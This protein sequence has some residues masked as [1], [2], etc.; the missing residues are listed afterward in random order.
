MIRISATATAPATASDFSVSG[1]PIVIGAGQTI[2][3]SASDVTITGVDDST[4]G[5]QKTVTVSGAAL[6]GRI[7]QPGAKTLTITDD[8]TPSTGVTLTVLPN[9]VAEDAAAAD[10]TVTVVA[11]LNGASRDTA[12]TITVSV[13]GVTATAGTHYVAVDDFAVTIPANSVSGRNTFTLEPVDDEVDAPDRTVRVTGTTTASGLTVTIVDDDPS[14]VVTLELSPG[15]ISEDGGVSTVTATLD[16][17]SSGRT[18]VDVTAA[19]VAPAVAGDYRLSGNKRLTI[20]AGQTASTGTVT[21]TGVDNEVAAANKEVEVSGT[22]TTTGTAV[23]QPDVLMLTITDN[24]QASTTVT[25]SVSPDAISEGATGSARTVQVTAALD[26]AARSTDTTV[27]MT[28]ASGTAIA[29]TDFAAVSDFTVTI[30]AGRRSGNATFA[31]TPLDD[32][33]DEPDET[34]LVTGSLSTPGLALEPEGGLTVTIEDNEPE[35]LV[36]LVLTPDSIREDGGATTVTATLDSPSTAVTTI[37]VAASPVAPAVEGDFRLIGSQLTISIGETASTGSVTIEAVDNEVEAPNKRVTVSATT[38]NVLGVRDPA[39]RTLTI[40]DNEF[41]STAVTLSVLPSEIGEGSPQT[42]EVSA[43]L[44]GAAR[45]VDTDIAITVGP[46]T[47]VASDFTPVNGFTLIIPAEQKSGMA[48]FTLV[49][50]NDET[51]EPDET[52]RVSGRLSGLRMEPSGGVTVTLVDDDD[53]PE[54]TLVLTPDS[55]I[56]NGGVST[57]T[58]SLDQR[59]SAMP[60]D[61][62]MILRWTPPSNDGGSEVTGYEYR[63]DGGAWS[64]VGGGATAAEFTVQNLTNGRT[65]VFGMRAVNGVGEGAEATVRAFPARPPGA[66][67]DLAVTSGDG[68][69]DVT[70]TAPTDDGG[71]PVTH[72]EVDIDRTGGWIRAS[73]SSSHRV[74]QL[75]N[76]TAYTFRVRA[77]NAAGGGEPSAAVSATPATVPGA[78]MAL[79]AMPRDGRVD[80]SWAAPSSDGGLAIS[81]YEVEVDGSGTWTSTGNT[82]T[83]YTVGGLTNGTTYRFRV[84]AVSDSGPGAASS[85]IATA[86][87]ATARAPDVPRAL[88][89]TPAD[90]AVTLSWIAPF[91]DGGAALLRYEVERDG[92]GT[93]TSTGNTSATYTAGGLTNGTSYRFRVRAVNSEGA[94]PATSAASAVPTTT[95][96]SRAAPVLLPAMRALNVTRASEASGS[97]T[98]TPAAMPGVPGNP[99]ATPGDG[100]VTLAWSAPAGS[101]P[102]T[103]YEVQ[104]DAGAWTATGGTA[105][106]YTVAG[107]VNGT[108]YTFRVRALNV[109]RASEASGSVTTTPTI[110]AGIVFTPSSVS[111]SEAESATYTVL[112]SSPPVGPLTVAPSV[113]DNVDV[114]VSPERLIFQAADWQTAQTVT[115]TAAA[116]T[117]EDSETATIRHTVTG[118]G[119]GAVEAGTV[120]VVVRD[121]S[122]EALTAVVLTVDPASVPEDAG[123]TPLTVTAQLADGSEKRDVEVTLSLGAGTAQEGINFVAVEPVTLTI[124]AG[125]A[126]ATA[127]VTLTPVDDT[128]DRPDGEDATVRIEASTDANTVVRP[129]SL[130]VT[131]ADDEESGLVVALDLQPG[132]AVVSVADAAVHEAAGAVLEFAV[133]LGPAQA[134]EIRVG[135]ATS[136]GT[137]TAGSDYSA[138]TGTLVFAAG[139]TEKTVSVPVLDDAIDEG[140]E[141]MTLTLVDRSGGRA[142]LADATATGTIEN[143]DS[144]PQAWLAR[145]GR[146]VAGQVLAAVETRFV[147]PR[148]PG[149]EVSLM[150]QRIGAS[151]LKDPGVLTEERLSA[152]EDWLRGGT[153]EGAGLYQTRELTNRDFLTGSAFNVTVGAEEEGFVSLWGHGTV[154]R[155]DGLDG[156][157]TLDGEVAS[158]ILGADLTQGR[159]AAGLA[160]SHARGTGDYRSPEGSGEVETALTGVYPW[161]RYMA[162]QRVSMWG[163]AGYGEGTLGKV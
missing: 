55:I 112:L 48:T 62:Q 99:T 94:G 146:T 70:W 122:S 103:G 72:F 97:V 61:G 60:A 52:V 64:P 106:S 87:T 19:P 73:R 153:G 7:V 142:H 12:T 141:T 22:A 156:E 3:S 120:H 24:D 124:P 20:A 105:T 47:A 114:T 63:V 35:P 118:A 46:G 27:A 26:G 37:T 33:I 131:I 150:G 85:S 86:P 163:V 68:W 77:V 144:M 9:R 10:Q 28:V 148:Q 158:G 31:L 25:L 84:R 92:D 38:E 152:R 117:D 125:S 126:S 14:P 42:I 155:F 123:P 101:E 36:T 82:S 100:E 147:A 18:T 110:A 30:A 130:E 108:S 83:T 5:N 34:V 17:P 74:N 132:L 58:A 29:T 157:I 39:D 160:L 56:E 104:V 162:S 21:V 16:R 50:T 71:A 23:E 40:T 151:A 43:E 90:S 67:A 149:T 76:G 138:A 116:D 59:L 121:R 80:L 54:V 65:Y 88:T 66:P 91:S 107:L 4:T 96:T 81:R 79:A 75:T 95:V 154:S 98:T 57:V 128:V 51:D 15:A 140:S 1:G 89:A 139:E 11:A 119:I 127:E 136:D 145:F 45:T 129:A 78:P 161:S 102:V 41:P 93:W 53:T 2:S 115:V 133:A 109:T 134:D 69:V 137:A 135:Y 44:D 8:D 13:T 49:P 6:G 32:E 159:V 111:V 113:T 143:A